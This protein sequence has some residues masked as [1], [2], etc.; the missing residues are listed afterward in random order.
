[1]HSADSKTNYAKQ[2]LKQFK[3]EIDTQVDQYFAHETKRVQQIYSNK[4][5]LA[6]LEALASV[7]ARGGKRLR[8]S[9]VYYTYQM[10]GGK[11]LAEAMKAALAIEMIHAYL[12]IE[13]DFMDLSDTRRGGPT[14]HKMMEK[15]HRENYRKGD[16][17]HA[18]NSLG[19]LASLMGSHLAMEIVSQLN[20]EPE[21]ILKM[22]LNLNQRLNTTVHGQINDVVNEYKDTVTEEEVFDVLH[23]KTAAYT[24]ENPIHFGAIMAGATD[25]DL[26][27][28]TGYSIPAGI[29]FQIQDDILGVFGEEKATGKSNLD[30]LKEGKITLL[31]QF[32][33]E[34]ADPQQRAIIKKTIGNRELTVTDLEVV[35]DI[36]RVTGSLE[37][38]KQKALEFVQEAKKC[39]LSSRPSNWS[40]DG[41]NYLLG[42]ADYMIERN[43]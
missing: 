22:M 28:L 12:L 35:R 31:V 13:D 40:D 33:L 9:F 32:A 7:T 1:M 25:E 15:F 14:G 19:V 24:Y 10:L 18:G 8:G 11:D 30:D 2:Q 34:H 4:D 29:A 20:A 5:S 41:F 21:T 3:E 23:W 6:T 43:L 17:V 38:S 27:L 26:E 37:Y 39:L 42:I 16:P 36:F